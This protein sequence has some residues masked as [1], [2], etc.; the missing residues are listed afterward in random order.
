M[1][2]AA[3]TTAIFCEHALSLSFGSSQLF[4]WRATGTVGVRRETGK[5]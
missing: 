4:P 3:E 2:V 1:P 5:E